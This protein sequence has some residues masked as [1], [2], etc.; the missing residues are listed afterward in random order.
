MLLIEDALEV[1]AYV[2]RAVVWRMTGEERRVV[3][4]RREAKREV[5]IIAVDEEKIEITC[6]TK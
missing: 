4:A 2:R 1:E 3:R 5:A 6:H